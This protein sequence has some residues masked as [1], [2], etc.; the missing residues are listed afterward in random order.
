[1]NLNSNTS[2]TNSQGD[3]LPVLQETNQ[4]QTNDPTCNQN[5]I[6]PIVKNQ[7]QSSE[8]NK[9]LNESDSHHI[10]DDSLSI[11]S[12][13]SDQISNHS[14][15][16]PLSP[17]INSNKKFP[18]K[19]NNVLKRIKPISK[20][21]PNIKELIDIPLIRTQI[22]QQKDKDAIKN[23]IKPDFKNLVSI[24]LEARNQFLQKTSESQIIDVMISALAK[25]AE[26]LN[27]RFG[28]DIV[29]IIDISG[30]MSG[31]KIELVRETLN[32]IIDEM[33]E[34]D[35]LS[36]VV[37]DDYA[38]ILSAL[39]PMT[40]QAKIDFKSIV[41]ER[42]KVR[43]NTNIIDGLQSGFEILLNRKMIND[44][45]AMF[46]LSDGQDSCGNN[47]SDFEKALI[48]FDA[49]MEEKTMSY[50]INSFGFGDGHDEKILAAISSFKNG[51]FYY[52]KNIQIV[53]E[54]FIECLGFLMSVIAKHSEINIKLADGCLLI[55]KYGEAWEKNSDTDQ[56]RI[57]LGMLAVGLEKNFI[58]QI[59]VPPTLNIPDFAIGSAIL[60]FSATDDNNYS[61]LDKLFMKVSQNED[62]G[63]I[64][65]QVEKHLTRV[66]AVELIRLA[67]KEYNSGDRANAK[68]KLEQFKVQTRLNPNLSESFNENMSD[69]M[70]N[71]I[72]SHDKSF[73][74]KEE[75][76]STQAFKPGMKNISSMNSIQKEMINKKRRK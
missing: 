70:D 6:D 27:K 59:H 46:I 47:V 13:H 69:I 54:C 37:F 43:G 40:D 31:E 51:N 74:E 17:K 63:E 44:V 32:F 12:D 66:K 28:L 61:V 7:K 55:K 65:R 3:Q 2:A 22:S 57:K 15:S 36:L 45:S 16:P 48:N 24:K 30:S 49:R 35:R 52:I 64:N 58:V 76:L 68:K 8:N 18:L 4:L 72:L 29:L 10:Q 33:K 42:V 14:S 9:S 62:I 50:R 75:A 39:T 41:D 19:N 71:D 73:V 25:N 56:A 20:I 38:E 67:K 23:E 53:D 1:M 34:I 5:Q 26:S 11:C 21:N 60:T